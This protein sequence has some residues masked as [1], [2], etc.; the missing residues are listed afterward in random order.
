MAFPLRSVLETKSLDIE[1]VSPTSINEVLELKDC[2]E[3]LNSYKEYW[4]VNQA[5]I[6]EIL[7]RFVCVTDMEGRLKYSNF[8]ELAQSD[9]I[10]EKLNLKS[11]AIQRIQ[12]ELLK[13]EMPENIETFLNGHICLITVNQQR[14]PSL[15]KIQS[16]M[17]EE[18][19]KLLI[20]TLKKVSIE[21]SSGPFAFSLD[22]DLNLTYKFLKFKFVLA[23]N[24]SGN[25]VNAPYDFFK[26]IFRNN[27]HFNPKKIDDILF[28]PDELKYALET[29][30]DASDCY[31]K[32]SAS[33]L[34][35][36]VE[37]SFSLKPILSAMTRL[38]S[39][40]EMIVSVNLFNSIQSKDNETVFPIQIKY[41]YD[42]DQDAKIMQTEEFPKFPGFNVIRKLSESLNSSVYEAVKFFQPNYRVIIKKIHA[43]SQTIQNELKFYDYFNNDP[44]GCEF[45]EKPIRVEV[46]PNPT[47]YMQSK[48]NQVDLFEYINSNPY[49]PDKDIQTMFFQIAK[50]VEYLHNNRIIHRDLKVRH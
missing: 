13:K 1:L 45:I 50:A 9:D 32:F 36:A 38:K 18:E 23:I 19:R 2:M 30:Y 4:E 40:S 17:D 5:T 3:T 49:L 41:Q 14:V 43:R 15:L 28:V 8:K 11:K 22:D 6:S 34:D 27:I 24:Q 46:E 37:E 21:E 26:Y 20:W 44:M 12:D 25:I 42:H 35:L 31:Q 10:I 47:I 39:Q 48:S 29:S 7:E 33:S 16:I